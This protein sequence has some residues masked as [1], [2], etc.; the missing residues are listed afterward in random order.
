MKKIIVTLIIII[1][2]FIKCDFTY[3]P[4]GSNIVEIESPTS[5]VNIS[6]KNAKDSLFVWGTVKL[7]CDI[8]IENKYDIYETNVYI[9]SIL[10]GK[11]NIEG[12]LEFNSKDLYDGVHELTVIVASYPDNN[13]LA[14]QL[15]REVVKK[16][17]SFKLVVMNNEPHIPVEIIGVDFKNG[18][19]TVKWSK[20]KYSNFEFYELCMIDSSKLEPTI[21]H[22]TNIY[23]IDSL[24]YVNKS[25]IGGKITY[26]VIVWTNYGNP[27]IKS[28]PYTY[29][30]DPSE[31]ID[32]K[33]NE[34]NELVLTWKKSKYKLNFSYYDILFYTGEYPNIYHSVGTFHNIDDTSNTIGV[35]I[36]FGRIYNFLVI[37]HGGEIAKSK[38]F[39]IFIG[40]RIP[41]FD[42][43]RY[44]PSTS[45]IY[46][47][48]NNET[49]RLDLNSHELL[50]HCNKK[51]VISHDGSR[52]YSLASENIIEELDPLNFD[53]LRTVNT[54][55]IFQNLNNITEIFIGPPNIL[56][57]N[58][59]T[60]YYI[61]TDSMKIISKLKTNYSSFPKIV[62]VSPHGYIYLNYDNRLI[63]ADIS[64]D[65][66]SDEG[67]DHKKPNNTCFSFKDNFDV[68]GEI[69]DNQ[70]LI[71]TF[72][73]KNLIES[74][75]F[76]ISDITKYSMPS[77]DPLSNFVGAVYSNELFN[78]FNSE[79]GEIE[80]YF[81]ISDSQ[82]NSF[83]LLNSKLY[84]NDGL[85]ID[86]K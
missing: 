52:A 49:S 9:D 81:Y 24:E 65:L 50:A 12:I 36:S 34:Y 83:H 22:L 55:N 56:Y 3:T 28:S 25:Y 19:S 63:M 29:Y 58:R 8:D 10:I 46:L 4:T 66:I 53:L 82:F 1:L 21:T 51:I 73:N 44:I 57:I 32:W 30:E 20:Y 74:K 33:F 42:E 31:I 27:N 48:R 77:I 15:Q 54:K 80:K 85:Y 86:I 60:I 79:T 61:D 72:D 38:S 26:L 39:P 67:F 7:I 45:S 41:K 43:L 75:G 16:I 2:L 18:Y 47:I 5:K 76:P 70:F 59:E 84:S 17:K 6:L 71:S 68:F 78:I 62:E 40:K 23:S 64:S 35:N 13:S 11:A 37:T 69:I 14:A